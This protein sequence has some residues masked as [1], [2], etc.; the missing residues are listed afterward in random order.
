MA[1]VELWREAEHRISVSEALDLMFGGTAYRHLAEEVFFWLQEHIPYKCGVRLGKNRDRLTFL[2]GNYRL[3]AI[4]RDGGRLR[5]D[6]GFHAEV[7][8]PFEV[9]SD[10]WK[11]IDAREGYIIVTEMP[12]P[13]SRSGVDSFI[14]A[15]RDMREVAPGT[16]THE[17][18][19]AVE[20]PDD[21][22][23]P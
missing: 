9:A 13:L 21:K 18:N 3:A 4:K 17:C 22:P 11:T 7:P 5:L 15:C 20:W 19:V 14:Q 6:M 16:K 2:I 1:G 8:A 10:V 12:L 23:L